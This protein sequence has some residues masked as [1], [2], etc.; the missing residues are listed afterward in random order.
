[1]GK[2]EWRATNADHAGRRGSKSIETA[3]GRPRNH[4]VPERR[5]H[6]AISH[7]LVMQLAQVN[8]SAMLSSPRLIAG[9]LAATLVLA[10]PALPA[11]AQEAEATR[12]AAQDATPS[13][14]PGSQAEGAAEGDPNPSADDVPDQADQ[15]DEAGDAPEQGPFY[16]VTH[17]E[18]RYLREHPDLPA[19]FELERTSVRLGRAADESLVAPD[20]PEAEHTVR[21]TIAALAD[22]PP[23]RYSAQA[24]QVILETL[25]DALPW[26]GVHV[27]PDPRDLSVDARD[28][29]PEDRT[30]MRI[31]ITI[32]RV[33][34]LRTQA[35]GERFVDE[36]TTNHPAHAWIRKRSPLQPADPQREEAGDLIDPEALDAYAFRLSRHP[37]R[38]VDTTLSAAEEL[39]GT[40]LDYVVTEN[41]P[42]SV[43]A[44]TANTGTKQTRRWRQTF[45]L[46]HHQFT[47]NDDI[48]NLE[49][50]TAS[51]DA[52]HAVRGSY[53]APIFG[54][55][56]VRLGIHAS[57]S[58]FTASDVGIFDDT[59]TGTTYDYGGDLTGNI[60]Q[61]RNLFLDV[62]AGAR[63]LDVT[64]DDTIPFTDRGRQRLFLPHL[65]F[66]LEHRS[67]W[68]ANHD[69]IEFAWHTPGVI[70]VDD[71][72]FNNLGR[73]EPDRHWALLSWNLHHWVYLEP[74]INREAWRDPSTPRSSTLAHQLAARFRGQ[75]VFRDKR[76]IPQLQRVAGGMHSV[77]GYPESASAGDTVL[78][79]SLEYRLRI[80]RL[81]PVEPDPRELFGRD[82]RFAPQ[83]VYGSPDWDVAPRAF[84][85]AARV[86]SNPLD[87]FEDVPDET[88]LGA[89]LGVDASYRRNLRIRLDWGIALSD[90]ENEQAQSGDHRLHFAATVLY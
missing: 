68:Y 59:F 43:Y 26:H 44:R 82:F 25:R 58:D 79:G 55:D 86:T 3:G 36:P 57:W 16:P 34:E 71:E 74:L 78:I 20:A 45:G 29:R 63:I 54:I 21:Y 7:K 51:F 73:A 64:V 12:D 4:A 22:E 46:M 15:E 32:G 60:F 17:F 31:V 37:G 24:L 88:L 80:P 27:A 56:R 84:F 70:N 40:T 23:Q 66:E 81:F 52:T 47:G 77:R 1:M 35:R 42:Y 62:F 6:P 90:L 41:R 53:E 89:G 61:R 5:D 76:L 18:L 39:A 67:E 65:G 14:G 13:N 48:L 28:L 49:Y 19:I 50:T 72:E 33:T 69:R 9:L 8:M 85:D 2:L 87:D 83:Y 30:A 75:H 38:R 11:I 10:T